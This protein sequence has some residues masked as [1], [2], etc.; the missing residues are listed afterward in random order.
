MGF[1]MISVTGAILPFHQAMSQSLL[2]HLTTLSLS[3]T[4]T[5]CTLLLLLLLLLPSTL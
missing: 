1:H 5:S 2:L 3:C 4:P